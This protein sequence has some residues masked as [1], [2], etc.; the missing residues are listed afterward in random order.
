MRLYYRYKISN[1]PICQTTDR[2]TNVHI[3]VQ[4]IN[5]SSVVGVEEKYSH[6]ASQT[7][8]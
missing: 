5:G 8:N 7:M 2:A 6:S 1:Q 4:K 3:T